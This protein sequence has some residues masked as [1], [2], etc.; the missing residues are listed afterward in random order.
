MKIILSGLLIICLLFISA[1][2]SASTPTVTTLLST[3][4]TLLGTK[5]SPSRTPT[6]QPTALRRY[7]ADSEWI[8]TAQPTVPPPSPADA[9]W[10]TASPETPQEEMMLMPY[11]QYCSQFAALAEDCRSVAG[12]YEYY[13]D[14]NIAFLEK[15]LYDK[16]YLYP[17]YPLMRKKT[18]D[19]KGV[20]IGI[21]GYNFEIKNDCLYIKSG[22]FFAN[23][24][25]CWTMRALSLK[26]GSVS[27]G[28]D[29]I[30]LYFP[31]TGTTVYFT[32]DTGGNTIY[33]SN[34]DL[35][36]IEEFTIHLPDWDIISETIKTLGYGEMSADDFKQC[37]F[38][39]KVE[40]GWIY[41]SD[42]LCMRSDEFAYDGIYRISLDGTKIEKVDKG[43]FTPESEYEYDCG[44]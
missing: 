6:A 19:T 36:D 30:N 13:F 27:E 32:H 15:D 35:T 44:A 3:E 26:D 21:Y 12:G 40:N 2:G 39:T 33:H 43:D 31:P 28:L 42:Q 22:N 29:S 1:C 23:D 41:F 10:T 17:D 4:A 7:Q 20:S 37:L 34:P 25:Q 5:P 24:W 8:Q 11:G 16:D 18:G 14:T 9:E 38:I